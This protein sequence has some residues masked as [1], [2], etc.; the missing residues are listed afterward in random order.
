MKRER[1][2]SSEEPKEK[3]G[4]MNRDTKI[5]LDK[6]KF[7]FEKIP[8]NTAWYNTFQ[9]IDRGEEKYSTFSNHCK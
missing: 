6:Y 5:V 8:Q 7:S 2:D 1:D 3:M 9:R 4:R